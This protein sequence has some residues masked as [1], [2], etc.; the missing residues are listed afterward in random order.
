MDLL[1]GYGSD[2][3]DD[4]L[5][6]EGKPPEQVE[7]QDTDAGLSAST[8]TD[9]GSRKKKID[10]S[11]LPVS[12]PLAIDGCSKGGDAS[13]T[14]DE[15]APLRR[16]A[17]LEAA[18]PSAARSLL[19]SLPAP[20]VT[21]GSEVSTHGSMR[22]DLSEISKPPRE[23]PTTT[24]GVLRA[25]NV[26]D[27]ILEDD[28]VVPQNVA[29]HPMFSDGSANAAALLEAGAGPTAE[30]LEEMRTV[31]NFTEIKADDIQDQNWYE[32]YH[33]LGDPGLHKGKKVPVEM[34]MYESS[35]WAQTTHANPSRIQKR[36]HQINWMA[37]DAMEKE[38]E[39]QERN[40]Q[41]RLTKAQTSMKYGW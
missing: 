2:G 24:V 33:A 26:P 18:R 5:V 20:K 14:G 38:A 34:S 27:R 21:L 15:E 28:V 23:L 17:Q 41:S 3:S 32:Q 35:R 19:A 25:E 39:L 1:G 9:S 6:A 4:D 12:R 31:K 37:Q 40:S 36:K 13:P 7:Q 16:A 22:I 11:R 30:E 8:S 29:S 10:Y